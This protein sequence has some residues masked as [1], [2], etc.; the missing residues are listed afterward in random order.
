MG[1]GWSHLR[2]SRALGKVLCRPLWGIIANFCVNNTVTARRG[3]WP[4]RWVCLGRAV[5]ER[6]MRSPN[7]PAWLHG[8]AR[9]RHGVTGVSIFWVLLPVQPGTVFASATNQRAPAASGALGTCAFSGFGSVLCAT[10]RK[11][12]LVCHWTCLCGNRG[13]SGFPNGTT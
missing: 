13:G 6:C 3:V 7:N 11:L 9:E 4:P 2:S 12:F 1:C 8:K 10:E 5:R